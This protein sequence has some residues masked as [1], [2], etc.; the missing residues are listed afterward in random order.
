MSFNPSPNLVI[1]VPGSIVLN[2]KQGCPLIVCRLPS[3][4]PRLNPIEPK[5]VYG[6]RAVAEPTRLLPMSELMERV[7]AYYE[8]ELINPIAQLDY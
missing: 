4:S 7:Y 8:C 5:W 3:K 6:K 2:E 1:D